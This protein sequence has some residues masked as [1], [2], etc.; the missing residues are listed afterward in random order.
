M[1]SS[2]SN[3]S[4]QI[5]DKAK[6]FGASLAGIADAKLLKQSPSHLIYPRMAHNLAVGSRKLADG[7]EPGQV[8]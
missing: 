4:G 6:S 2:L 3:I 7:I 5:I 1:A 8:A